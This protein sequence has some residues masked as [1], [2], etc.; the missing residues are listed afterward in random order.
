MNRF[1]VDLISSCRISRKE[2]VISK[3]SIKRGIF[4]FTQF[5]LP[6][7]R[8]E[9]MIENFNSTKVQLFKNDKIKLWFEGYYTGGCLDFFIPRSG[10]YFSSCKKG[11]IFYFQ[12][13]GFE[14]P[15]EIDTGVERY[16]SFSKVLS[17]FNLSHVPLLTRGKNF[18]LRSLTPILIDDLMDG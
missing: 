10:T 2:S 7:G 6:N 13:P 1:M 8:R 5:L 17:S 15:F 4:G 12:H 16:E 14:H 3:I 18:T 9:G 11:Y